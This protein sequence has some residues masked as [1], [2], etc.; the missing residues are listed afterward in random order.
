MAENDF[1]TEG[2]C[3]DKIDKVYER[4][5]KI[6]NNL[7]KIFGG[8]AVITFVS[9]FAIGAVS[10]HIT[11]RFSGVEKTLDKMDNRLVEVISE[12]SK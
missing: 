7:A 6:D 3:N 10:F 2:Q 11:Q 5:N 8:I 4:M 1:V 12:H 9:T